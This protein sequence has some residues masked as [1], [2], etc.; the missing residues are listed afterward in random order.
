MLV[1][2]LRLY[3]RL[4]QILQVILSVGQSPNIVPSDT[5]FPTLSFTIGVTTRVWPLQGAPSKFEPITLPG[6]T[7]IVKGRK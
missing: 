6:T 3:H 5:A 4:A 1:T 7:P 2:Q